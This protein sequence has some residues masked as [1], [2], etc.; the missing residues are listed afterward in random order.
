MPSLTNPADWELSYWQQGALAARGGQSEIAYNKKLT[1]VQVQGWLNGYNFATKQIE[2]EIN[3]W[4]ANA[5]RSTRVNIH[6]SIR[7]IDFIDSQ[8]GT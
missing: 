7:K 8:Q 6:E 5:N 1:P 2:K 4:W 3:I